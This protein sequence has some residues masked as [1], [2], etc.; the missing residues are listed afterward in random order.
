MSILSVKG[1]VKRFDANEVL[2]GIDLEVE[3]GEVVALIGAS[4]SG[5]STLLRCVNRLET[6]TQGTVAFR[7]ERVGPAPRPL[8]H[9]A[10]TGQIPHNLRAAAGVAL[11]IRLHVGGPFAAPAQV[12][13]GRIGG[14]QGLA[15]VVRGAE[16][17]RRTARRFVPH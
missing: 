7:G 10:A 6:P 4:G 16:D 2:K 13:K 12:E 5:K 14:S 9:R 8:Q 17:H 11:D 1:L 15:L 3:E